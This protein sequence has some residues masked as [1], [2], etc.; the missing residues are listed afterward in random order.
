MIAT[1]KEFL[2]AV[3]KMRESQKAYANSNSFGDKAAVIKHEKT[4]DDAIKLKRQKWAQE[5]QP[6]IY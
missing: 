3:E 4:V 6:E 2:I 1:W 5:A